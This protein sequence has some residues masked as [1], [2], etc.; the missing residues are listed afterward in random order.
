MH[1]SGRTWR[2][3]YERFSVIVEATAG[4]THDAC[5]FCSLYQDEPFR[6]APLSQFE[7]DLAEI[8]SHQPRA[9]RVFW[10]GGNPFAMGYEQLKVRALLTREYLPK[11]QSIAMFA[12]VPDIL[13]KS[14]QQ[15]ER[16]RSFGIN[17]LS[18]G[19]E[20]G[21]D[22]TLALANKGYTASEL[23]EAGKRLEAAGIEYYLVYMT[24]LAGKDCGTRNA[25]ASAAAFNQLRPYI[26]AVDALTLFPGTELAL[27]AETGQFIP[28]GEKER[29]KEL[30]V[31]VEA[32]EIRT[33]LLADT[34]TN[35]YPL[36]AILPKERASLLARLDNLLL[37]A[38][39]EAMQAYR[40]G[41][42]TPG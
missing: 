39:E 10:T 2:P 34:V 40:K 7:A 13:S 42:S 29:L 24:G 20:S 5:R 28:A 21:D 27:M 25:L 4:C 23:V 32:L 33:H 9:R 16:L 8:R 12:R 31:F 26:V 6:M 11:C 22:E 3:P 35:V 17:G 37:T 19:A 1:F 38:D 36:Q 14:V 15:L 30:R 41:L 18:I